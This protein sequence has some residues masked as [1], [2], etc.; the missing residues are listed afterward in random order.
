M[1]DNKTINGAQSTDEKMQELFDL[2]N[3]KA[4]AG[5]L[6]ESAEL[7]QEE[8]D[9][10]PMSSSET[11]AY[12]YSLM[13][14]QY[15]AMLLDYQRREAEEA[16][17]Q[18]AAEKAEETAAEAEYCGRSSPRPACAWKRSRPSSPSRRRM[19]TRTWLP[20]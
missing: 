10:S 17:E 7:P 12:E 3:E 11:S 4:E 20:A 1:P 19:T 15:E 6:D 2:L 13:M 8:V 9:D 5:E 18:E 14:K 16:A